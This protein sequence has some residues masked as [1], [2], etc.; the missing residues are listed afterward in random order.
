MKI[1]VSASFPYN[2]KEGYI[3]AEEQN[4]VMFISK[5]LLQTVREYLLEKDI[6]DFERFT[7]LHRDHTA[8]YTSD[9]PKDNK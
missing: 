2:N 9:D 4:G 3:H 7:V 6:F 5:A 1:V 8:V